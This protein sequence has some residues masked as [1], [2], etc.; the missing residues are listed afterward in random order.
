[1]TI[2][3]L[4]DYNK[5]ISIKDKKRL[6]SYLLDKPNLVLDL[7]EEIS[8]DIFFNYENAVK[9]LLA[10]KPLQYVLGKTTFYGYDFLVNEQVLIPRFET[11]LLV[12]KT[13]AYINKYF[14]NVGKLIDLGCGTGAIGITI[15]KECPN[16]QV[17]LLDISTKALK[18]ARKNKRKLKADVAIVKGDMLD[19]VTDKYDIIISNPPYIRDDE[20]IDA[21]V[22]NNEPHLA[23]YGGENGLKYYDQ[24]LKRVAL[25]TKDRFLLALE[26]GHNQAKDI[27]NLVNKYL[28]NVTIKIEKDL[29][30]RNRM[31]FVTHNCE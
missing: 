30:N 20:S 2:K 16:L 8:S 14:H 9:K 6:I 17:T 31:I 13:L 27:V 3:D 28:P 25:T 1:M 29:Q 15:K 21:L 12:E 26:I 7:E 19:L 24:I 23:L 22:K 18:V 5:Q 11:E 10:G 4:L